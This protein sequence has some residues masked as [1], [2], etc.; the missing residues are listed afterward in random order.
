MTTNAT[1]PKLQFLDSNGAPLVGGKLYTYA[2]GTTTPLATYTDYGGATANANPVILDSRG[3]ASVWLGT[4]LYKMA[5]YD[6]T[7]VLVWTVDN[8]GGFATLAQLAA[9]GGS[10]LVGYLPA[11]TGAV[12]T[13]VQSKLRT[14]VTPQDFGA[15]GDGTT[16]DW[17]AIKTA[18][19]AVAGTDTALDFGG[20]TYLINSTETL[21]V[22]EIFAPCF[23]LPATKLKIVGK[24]FTLQSG[25]GI[26]ALCM[27]QTTYGSTASINVSGGKISGTGV[28]GTSS[29]A[30]LDGVTINGNTQ[31]AIFNL[32]IDNT[33]RHGYFIIAGAYNNQVR[34]KKISNTNRQSLGCAVQ[35][36]GARDNLVLID[37]MYQCGANGIDIN[38][39]TPGGYYPSTGPW[40]AS[41]Q[42]SQYN[43]ARIYKIDGTGVNNSSDYNPDDDYYGVNILS[44]NYN[45]ID[46][47]EI[48]SVRTSSGSISPALSTYAAAVRVGGGIGN[49]VRVGKV[50]IVGPSN[51][52]AVAKID[53]PTDG[54][55][56]VTQA[57]FYTNAVYS[58]LSTPTNA[59]GFR[60]FIRDIHGA[61]SPESVRGLNLKYVQ[62][63]T[64]TTLLTGVVSGW[65]GDYGLT[66]TPQANGI[67]IVVDTSTFKQLHKPLNFTVPYVMVNFEYNQS[68][69]AGAVATASMDQSPFIALNLT[70]DATWRSTSVLIPY[71]A[72][73]TTFS[74][75]PNNS[76]TAASG[77]TLQIR[78]VSISLPD[79]TSVYDSAVVGWL[80]G[81]PTVG[82]YVI[83]D[84]VANN[85][86]AV[87]SPK[88]W[89]CTVAGT[90]GTWVSEGNL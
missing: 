58:A 20:Y 40:G 73:T 10:N 64:C 16:N 49:V 12:A 18:I 87:G 7:N 83:G 4:A 57:E 66:F 60:V 34:S 30:L 68:N 24:G 81:A 3:E 48:K 80:N 25:T 5:L 85:N 78:N 19:A 79:G 37:E 69:T 29:Y 56:D 42:T 84:K 62:Q 51:A 45:T 90:P 65:T 53:S 43:V 17:S 54:V 23:R 32:E 67:Q 8:I 14:F 63:A 77:S 72:A 9:S 21:L 27:F 71:A 22:Y 89:V 15:K 26:Q 11:G 36:E 75:S 44:G 55:I 61:I 13:T 38:T 28:A 2:A 70:K 82:T 39:F 33:N 1:P 59:A 46:V 74:F 41:V 76:G 47:E 6:S 88:G 35:I 52:G 86:A 31:N 50:S